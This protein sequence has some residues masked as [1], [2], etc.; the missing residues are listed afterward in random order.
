MRHGKMKLLLLARTIV[1]VVVFSSIMFNGS[2]GADAAIKIHNQKLRFVFKYQNRQEGIVR[3]YIC[4]GVIFKRHEKQFNAIFPFGYVREKMDSLGGPSNWYLDTIMISIRGISGDTKTKLERCIN[5]LNETEPLFS[6][7][8]LL[9]GNLVVSSKKVRSILKE[10][11][12]YRVKNDRY[13][14]ANSWPVLLVL[15]LES[16]NKFIKAINCE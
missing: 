16:K 10:L 2:L 7:S 15:N 1:V 5:K 14:G 4:K 8:I 3:G 9:S 12:N 6:N 13:W 11:E